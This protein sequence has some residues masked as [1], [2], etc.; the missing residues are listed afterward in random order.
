M[1]QEG[2]RV[3]TQPRRLQLAQLRQYPALQDRG[4]RHISQERHQ[5]AAFFRGHEKGE[6]VVGLADLVVDVCSA[7]IDRQGRGSATW[8]TDGRTTRAFRG[9]ARRTTC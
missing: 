2:S 7:L 4:R 5:G 6:R 8:S 3:D 9:G 1:N